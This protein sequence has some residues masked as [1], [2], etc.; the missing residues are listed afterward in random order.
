[1]VFRF[2]HVE[3]DKMADSRVHLDNGHIKLKLLQTIKNAFFDRMHFC[4][5]K[6]INVKLLHYKTH[7][8]CRCRCPDFQNPVSC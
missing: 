2:C 3:A 4:D 5:E 7:I 6:C 1:M 8:S